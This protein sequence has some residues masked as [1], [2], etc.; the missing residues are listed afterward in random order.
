MWTIDYKV[1]WRT[2]KNTRAQC[3]SGN[4]QARVPAECKPA[5]ITQIID[6][7]IQP[8]FL[9]VRN[10]WKKEYLAWIC[11][12]RERIRLPNK[13]DHRWCR[14][15]SAKRSIR[16]YGNVNIFSMD[17]YYLNYHHNCFKRFH[18]ERTHT[19]S[20]THKKQERLL[21]AIYVFRL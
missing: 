18:P 15:C 6:S 7:G 3:F 11:C 1:K 9:P 4:S 19:H 21:F 20:L 16:N 2:K 13:A 12:C 17:L 5:A 8:L 10:Q 14:A